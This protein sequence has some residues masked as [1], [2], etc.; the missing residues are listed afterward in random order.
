MPEQSLVTDANSQDEIHRLIRRSCWLLDK[1]SFSEWLDLFES[2]ATYEIVAFSPEIQ[3]AMSWMRG[4]REELRTLIE[5]LPNHVRED[6]KRA[7]FLMEIDT[8]IAKASASS[9]SRFVVFKTNSSGETSVYAVGH[10]ED[11]LSRASG[12]WKVTRR[13]VV[14]DT[15]MFD[16]FPHMIPL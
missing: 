15:R 3:K 5:A 6:A 8:T 2:K 14:L 4:T 1:E 7:H 12:T 11:D 16:V 9:M 13:R 10:Y